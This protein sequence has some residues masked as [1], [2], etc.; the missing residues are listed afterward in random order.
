[1]ILRKTLALLTAVLCAFLCLPA[2]AQQDTL[3]AYYDAYNGGAPFRAWTIEQQYAFA[4]E[5][6]ALIEE[7]SQKPGFYIPPSLEE[8]LSHSYGLPA[9]EDLTQ[10]QAQEAAITFL[11]ALGQETEEELRAAT[12]NFSFL[13][14]DPDAPLWLINVYNGVST[15]R[16]R[17][18]RLSI[19]SRS[20]EITLEY[21]H[22]ASPEQT[23]EEILMVF[24]RQFPDESFDQTYQEKA[25]IGV[26]A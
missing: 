2:H 8:V 25:M 12:W 9:E 24:K 19:L 5:L 17:L 22:L 15:A 3:V 11:L 18:Y 4:S 21:D 26:K 14:D 20:G 10:G 16:N 13:T 7:Y 23:P 6:P 1:M